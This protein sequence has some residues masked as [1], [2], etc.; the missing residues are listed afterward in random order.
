[1]WFYHITS[2][3]NLPSILEHGLL[4][5]IP[6][7]ESAPQ[8]AMGYLSN[9][10]GRLLDLREQQVEECDKHGDHVILEVWL[11]EKYWVLHD[12]DM[13]SDGYMTP[14]KIPPSQ[15]TV[16]TEDSDH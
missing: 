13:D 15:I 10:L 9:S 5:K 11:N 6:A 1:M 3:E 4:P 12:P 7:I 8:I 2:T 16:I 14:S